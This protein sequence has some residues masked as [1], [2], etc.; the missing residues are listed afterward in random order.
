MPAVVVSSPTTGKKLADRIK[1]GKPMLILFHA[2]W[3]PHC[4][5]Y[6]GNPPSASYP[7]GQVCK[8][9]EGTFGEDVGVYEV[10][11]EKM[12]LL[13]PGMPQVQGF[14]TLMFHDGEGFHEFSGDRR[15]KTAVVAFIKT[16]TGGAKKKTVKK[17]NG[18]VKKS[19][20]A[21][22]QQK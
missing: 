21:K 7:W 3:C 12:G 2:H 13:P 4:V 5:D 16:H 22:K 6:I 17:K 9:V 15:D 8:Q 20:G 1:K 11:S 18:D 19:A 10:E 14:P